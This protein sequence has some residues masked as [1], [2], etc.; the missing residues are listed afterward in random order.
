MKFKSLFL[1]YLV[2]VILIGVFLAIF[3]NK[4]FI[5]EEPPAPEQ[6]K[7]PSSEF[8]DTRPRFNE[9]VIKSKKDGKKKWEIKAEKLL[10]DEPK[11]RAEAINPTCFFYDPSGKLYISFKTSKV[12]VDMKSKDIFFDHPS[13]GYFVQSGDKVEVKKMR[14]DSKK[15]IISG[16]S[17]IKIYRSDYIMTSDQFIADPNIKRF[18]LK[19]NVKGSWFGT[20]PIN[21]K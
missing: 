16:N 18:S 6:I 10:M 19:K 11:E 5:T 3:L 9:T 13:V 2:P 7:I 1:K 21:I 17:G 20:M 12:Y 8:S 15:S 4:D 14:W